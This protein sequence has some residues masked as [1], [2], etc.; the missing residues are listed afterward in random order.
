MA[1]SVVAFTSQYGGFGLYWDD[2]TSVIIDGDLVTTYAGD[3]VI[4]T[5]SIIWDNNVYKL[6]G[7]YTCTP[8]PNKTRTKYYNLDKLHRED[9]PAELLII[10]DVVILEDWRIDGRHHREDAPAYIERYPDGQISHELWCLHGQWH[11]EGEPARRLWRADGQLWGEE[12]YI[13]SKHHNEAGPSSIWWYSNEQIAHVVY[14][15]DDKYVDG[16]SIIKW[17]TNGQMEYTMWFVNDKRHK[18]DGPAFQEWYPNGQ[19]K[20]EKWCFNDLEHREDG[21]AHIVWS[22]DGQKTGETFYLHGEK[23]EPFDIVQ[24]L[25][26][27]EEDE[28]E[29]ESLELEAPSRW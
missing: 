5:F 15:I 23:V 1:L 24:A 20:R 18:I 7:I 9:G 3:A 12:W 28:S 2:I 8:S 14:C 10:N 11:R 29:D 6:H 26:E 21:P 25:P 27:D 13:N 17:Y 22:E 4:S 16:Q 19:L